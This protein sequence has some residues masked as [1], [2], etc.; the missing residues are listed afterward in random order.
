MS[1]NG[2]KEI[3]AINLN[4]P[5]IINIFY[6]GKPVMAVENYNPLNGGENSEVELGLILKLNSKY[7]QVV[8]FNAK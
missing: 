1:V 3:W 8:K 6:L 7:L 4:D 2:S 5:K